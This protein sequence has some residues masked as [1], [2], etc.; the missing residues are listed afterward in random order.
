MQ[1]VNVTFPGHTHLLK[2]NLEAY[3]LS[4]CRF[5]VLH[6]KNEIFG[7]MSLYKKKQITLYTLQIILINYPGSGVVLDCI[8]SSS[9]PP[10]LL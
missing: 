10:F 7:L 2:N 5:K 6:Y 4:F 9:L 3:L 8:D 1:F